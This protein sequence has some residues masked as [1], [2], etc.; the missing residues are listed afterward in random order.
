[1]FH[2]VQMKIYFF[3]L[4]LQA[5]LDSL[6]QVCEKVETPVEDHLFL[7]QLLQNKNLQSLITVSLIVISMLLL[8]PYKF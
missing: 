2:I 3:I 7:S 4:A 6:D 5:L 8:G 1:M